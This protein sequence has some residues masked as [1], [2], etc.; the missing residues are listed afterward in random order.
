[1]PFLQ[2]ELNNTERSVD[3]EEQ[4]ALPSEELAL[5]EGR[6]CEKQHD[7]LLK[8]LHLL[9]PLSLGWR[10]RQAF[11]VGQEAQITSD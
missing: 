8:N 7:P 11:L 1:M 3:A 5:S 4:N 9:D 6:H 10:Q 2:R